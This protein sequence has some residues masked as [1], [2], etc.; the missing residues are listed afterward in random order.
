MYIGT[1]RINPTFASGKYP[2]VNNVSILLYKINNMCFRRFLSN[3][4]I[5]S[6]TYFLNE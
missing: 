6:V 5:E 3:F 4:L 2:I 1:K